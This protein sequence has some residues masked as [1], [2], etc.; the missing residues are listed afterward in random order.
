[1]TGSP[2]KW[3]AKNQSVAG[4]PAILSSATIWPLP[5]A[6][7]VSVMLAN[8]LEHQHRRQRQLGIARAE[9]LAAPAG[10]QILVLDSSIDARP[11]RSVSC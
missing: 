4:L 8:A 1:M 7:P 9:Q 3:Q 2:L 5:C 6:P 11:S 10:E